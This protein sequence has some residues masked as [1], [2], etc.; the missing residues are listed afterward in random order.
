MR[1]LVVYAHPVPDSFNA[2]IHARLLDSL[3]AAGHEV[4]DLD[5][6]AIGFDPVLTAEERR[7]YLGPAPLVEH[8]ADHLFALR[9]AE[10]L[11]FVYPTW[12]YSLPAILK[13]WIDRVFL[14]HET[15]ELRTG[16]NP[17]QGLLTNLR[18]LGGIT[19]YGS[20]WWWIRLVAGDPGRAVIMRGL[21]PLCA[22]RCR[23]VW[24]GLHSMDTASA[25]RRQAFLAR[26]GALA[27]RL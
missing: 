24:L 20:P 17:M 1:I 25:A 13:G 27:T 23:T 16:L 14:P 18:L 3:K 22:K 9:W 8:V 26:V 11:I 7:A 15:F 21:R 10:G 5:L 6:Y 19:T 12:W 2:A 4:R